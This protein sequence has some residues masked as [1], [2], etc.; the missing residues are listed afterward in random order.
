MSKTV[1]QL[2]AELREARLR[3]GD[4]VVEGDYKGHPTLT[5]EGA[6]KPFSLGI[7]KLR[8][9]VTKI[10]DVKAFVEKHA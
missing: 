5:F 3:E 2:E 4:T 6:G 10:D 1:A 8:R 7:G 9:V